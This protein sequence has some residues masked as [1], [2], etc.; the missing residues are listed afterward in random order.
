MT[1]NKKKRKINKIV[2]SIVF[3]NNNANN[4]ELLQVQ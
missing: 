1:S 4:S 3:I 2:K